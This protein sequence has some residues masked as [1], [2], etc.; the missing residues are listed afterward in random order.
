MS[1]RSESS[2]AN[3]PSGERLAWPA[4]VIENIAGFIRDAEGFVIGG[5][6]MLELSSV[7]FRCP[8]N[9]FAV[10]RRMLG[11]MELTSCVA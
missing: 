9:Q 3:P 7:L 5:G 1:R 10:L 6:P 2:C 8:M 11:W 4:A